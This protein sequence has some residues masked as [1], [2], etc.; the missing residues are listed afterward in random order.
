MRPSSAR[1]AAPPAKSEGPAA[2]RLPRADQARNLKTKPGW[3]PVDVALILARLALTFPRYALKLLFFPIQK[4]IE[5]VDRHAAVARALGA[6]RDALPI[7]RETDPLTAENEAESSGG[8]AP[9]VELD[10]FSGLSAGLKAFDED[11]AGHGEYGSAEVRIGG[12][13]DVAAQLALRAPRFG[14]SHLWLE[15]MTR[16]E[17]EP[18]LLFSGI[19]RASREGGGEGLDP[20]RAAVPTRYQ[21]QRSTSM[22][23]AGY[24]G[25][26]RGRSLQLGVTA[27]YSVRDVSASA[28]QPS[29]ETV[30]DTGQLAGFGERVSSL[31]TDLNVTFDT[32]KPPLLANSG[33]HVDLFAGRVPQLTGYRYWHE[34]LDAIVYVNLYRGDRVLALRALL[35]GVQGEHGY[36]PFAD[37][38]SLGGPHR[39]RGYA[40]DRFRDAAA[41]LASVDYHYPIHQYVAGAL[42]VEA[43]RVESSFGACF[44]ARWSSSFG[45]GFFIRSREKQ[46]F[47]FHFAYGDALRFYLTTDP[48]RVFAKRDSEL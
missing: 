4:S 31:E 7:T 25:G 17:S 45:A 13:Y 47:S 33:V 26:E 28:R 23:R 39:L 16:Y 46:L 38:P 27:L 44:D 40:R 32:L 48:W 11:L 8:V 9:Q 35:E 21:Q 12:M 14:G 5:L 36:V 6:I 1:A 37:L 10:S 20:R 2:P 30:Y 41:A 34:G 43:G 3:D 29:I 15:S 22:L 24:T 19:G 18:A 42:F